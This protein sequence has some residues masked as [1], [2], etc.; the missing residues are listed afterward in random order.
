MRSLILSA[1]ALVFAMPVSAE[2]VVLRGDEHG[3]LTR[4]VFYFGGTPDW[5]VTETGSG[6]D[7]SFG[8]DTLELETA[9]ISDG[10]E[11][12]R[13]AGIDVDAGSARVSIATGC[14]CQVK[15]YLLTEGILVLDLSGSS[16]PIIDPATIEDTQGVEPA[17]VPEDGPARMPEG[18]A[19]NLLLTPAPGAQ[20]Q[21]FS[22]A[23][24]ASRFGGTTQQDSAA[25]ETRA[26]VEDAGPV[27]ERADGRRFEQQITDEAGAPAGLGPAALRNRRLELTRD[28]VVRE[29]ARAT[30]QGLL[31]VNPNS[32]E[33]TVRRT[34][35]M[36]GA[37]PDGLDLA[38]L[39]AALDA[40]PNARARTSMD[41]GNRTT[42]LDTRQNADGNYCIPDTALEI[43]AWGGA[44]TLDRQIAEFRQRLVGEFDQPD[45]QAILELARRYLY[46]SF[47]AEARALLDA[48]TIEGSEARRLRTMAEIMDNGFAASPGVFGDQLSC[49]T[50]AAFWAVLAQPEISRNSIVDRPAVLRAFSA[51]PLH[52]RRHLGPTLA[53]RFL[54]A[55]DRN[56][57]FALRDAIARAPGEHGEAFDW[58]A[59][60]ID[61][62]LGDLPAA[63]SRLDALAAKDGTLAAKALVKRVEL[64][65]QNGGTLPS[66]TVDSVAA[67]AFEYRGTRDGAELARAYVLANIVDGRYDE[68]LS[69]LLRIETGETTEQDVF[70]QLWSQLGSGM[71]GAPDDAL[72]LS[73]YYRHRATLSSRTLSEDAT[74]ALANRLLV[75]GLSEE[76]VR[77]ME[78]RKGPLA[79]ESHL[80]KANAAVRAGELD[81]ANRE[82]SGLEGPEADRLRA[83]LAAVSGEHIKAAEIFARLGD[84]EREVA[85]SW[86]TGDWARVAG[87]GEGVL[88]DAASLMREAP[89]GPVASATAVGATPISDNTERLA[90]SR[91]IRALLTDLLDASGAPE[92][93][94]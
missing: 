81:V 78:W 67:L 63:N 47:G 86:R 87:S 59:A 9:Q 40:L 22:D 10:A 41:Q 4:L 24:F 13:I 93:G 44:G 52:L 48:F 72:F 8:F 5:Q 16:E 11:L 73:A 15:P 17:G 30:S 3:D 26:G 55:G 18:L 60:N 20:A 1:L 27:A 31:E 84:T 54:E 25:L 85:L 66:G 76:A 71:A 90:E 28:L 14:D 36:G 42:V 80:L 91:R 69:S 77:V 21:R 12:A 45:T 32:P 50:N 2:R 51:M 79:P 53:L 61:R 92:P 58:L 43:S 29:L 70:P 6:F 37:A 64:A 68:A 88:L 82:L 38:A 83:E 46:L 65:I 62:D 34:P 56:T 39:S 94:S 89:P 57:S 33:V 23:Y 19:S 74:R 75:V 35:G 7:I 49:Q